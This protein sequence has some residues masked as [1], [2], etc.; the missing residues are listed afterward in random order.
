MISP[1]EMVWK[2]WY[3]QAAYRLPAA[4]WEVVLRYGTYEPPTGVKTKQ[5]TPG[6]SYVF[7][8]HVIAK[9]AYEVNDTEGVKDD[10]RLLLQLAYGF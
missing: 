9:L 2:A 6:I 3:T 10:D 5:W 8:S 4:N 1:G 7:A